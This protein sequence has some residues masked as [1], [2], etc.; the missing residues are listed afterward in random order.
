[1]NADALD[2]LF[3]V[4]RA[5]ILRALFADTRREMYVREISRTAELALR[6]VQ[7]ELAILKKI[8]LVSSRS[9][10]YHVFYRADRSHILFAPLQKLAVHSAGCLPRPRKE[11]KRPRQTWRSSGRRRR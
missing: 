7:R 8:G 1:M 10:G 11:R 6:T 5:E 9:N 2:L 4:V 3:P